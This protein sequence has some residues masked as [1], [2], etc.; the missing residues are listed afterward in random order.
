VTDSYDVVDDEYQERL[1]RKLLWM[2]VECLWVRL[3]GWKQLQTRA[4]A[5]V[6]KR[7]PL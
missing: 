6:A 1:S 4:A 3:N 7:P 5:D 2:S